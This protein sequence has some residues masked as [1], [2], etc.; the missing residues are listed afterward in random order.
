MRFIYQSDGFYTSSNYT[1]Y[2]ILFYPDI[3]SY[4]IEDLQDKII[5]LIVDK[6]S[7]KEME[8]YYERRDI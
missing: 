6:K 2:I 5:W 1:C 4:T 3:I 8:E 7:Y